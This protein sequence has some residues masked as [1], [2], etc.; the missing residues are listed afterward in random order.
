MGTTYEITYIDSTH[1]DFTSPIDTLLKRI[2]LS[3][4][5][6]I[7]TSTISRFNQSEDGLKADVYM[8]RMY[9]ESQKVYRTTQGAFDPTVMPLVNF[10]GF[11]YEKARAEVDTSMVSEIMER[12]GFSKIKMEMDTSTYEILLRKPHPKLELDFSAIAKGF[13][14]DEIGR[15]LSKRKV[16][17]Y[18]VNIGG[19]VIASGT[20][21]NGQLWKLGVNTPKE[22]APADQYEEL[23]YLNNQAMATS[24]NYRNFKTVNGKKV[25]HTINPKTGYPEMSSLL[26]T[27]IVAKDCTTA[28]AYATACMVMGFEKAQA[29]LRK[30]SSLGGMLIYVDPNGEQQVWKE[31]IAVPVQ[32]N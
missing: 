20:K 14:V 31:G 26:S 17:N 29:L 13:A 11:G 19:E 16:T 24:G 23:V 9:S 3:L 21:P 28:D 22:G 10:W 6:Y 12:V 18:L 32:N 27:T 15:W 4:S 8:A 1:R 7:P 2:N 30:D 25:V 5:T